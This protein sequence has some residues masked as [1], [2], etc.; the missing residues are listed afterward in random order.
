MPIGIGTSIAAGFGK[1]NEAPKPVFLPGTGRLTRPLSDLSRDALLSLRTGGAA[2][3]D[4]FNAGTAKQTSLLGE[5]EGIVRSIL[6]R[7]LGQSPEDLLRTVGNTAFGFINPNVVDPLS[8]FDVNSDRIRRLAAGLSPGAI[9]S[10]AQRLRDARIASG[11]YYDTARQ[12]YGALPGLYNQVFNAG[13][14]NDE[15]ASS[16]LPSIMNAYRR[17]DRAPLEAA[18]LRARAAEQG[19]PIVGNTADA[20]RKGVY[21]YLQPTNWADKLG[22]VD[23]EMRKSLQDA[24]SM[25]SQ[26]YGMVGGMGGGG[27]IGGMMGGGGGGGGNVG[28]GAPSNQPQQPRFIPNAVPAA[29]AYPGY[30]PGSVN[31]YPAPATQPQYIPG[32]PGFQNYFG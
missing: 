23:L 6:N 26:V 22:A 1:S 29:P 30:N 4:A 16:Y 20:I 19:A 5:Q 15:M 13:V 25:A 8:R 32:N 3:E 31:P 10:T 2:A 9:D 12:V 18:E 21:G 17:L 14:T 11:R 27:G 28:A 7:R 24:V